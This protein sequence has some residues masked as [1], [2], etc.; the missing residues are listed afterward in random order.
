MTYALG[1]RLTS[2]DA[3]TIGFITTRTQPN[4]HRI[5]DTIAEIALSTPFRMRQP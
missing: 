1:R 2:E 5:Q 4:G 3:K